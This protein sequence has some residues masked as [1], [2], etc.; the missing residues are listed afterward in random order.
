MDDLALGKRSQY[1]WSVSVRM[2]KNEKLSKKSAKPPASAKKTKKPKEPKEPVVPAAAVPAGKAQEEAPPVEE[3]AKEKEKTK[4]DRLRLSVLQA[5]VL[6]TIRE[7]PQRPRAIQTIIRGA[8]GVD[9]PR[10]EVIR[11]L[12][13]LKEKGLVEKTTAKAWRAK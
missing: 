11:S 10:N 1:P 7:R 6:E 9:I 4:R 5:A 8:G 12:N 3:V 13:E 2:P